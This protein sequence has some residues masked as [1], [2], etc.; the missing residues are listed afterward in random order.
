V[1]IVIETTPVAAQEDE[2]DS[3]GLEAIDKLVG[4]KDTP[5]GEAM[6]RDHDKCLYG[7]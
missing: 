2:D 6:G 3:R 5:L 4:V 1:H 7:N